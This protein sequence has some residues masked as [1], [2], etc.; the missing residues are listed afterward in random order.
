MSIK[1]SF[2][3]ASLLFLLAASTAWCQAPTV[4]APQPTTGTV[5]MPADTVLAPGPQA[6]APPAATN[7]PMDNA[8]AGVDPVTGKPLP[9]QNSWI[10]Y[11]QPGCCGPVGGNGPIMMELFLRSGTVSP[12]GGTRMSSALGTGWEIW[13]GGRSLFFNTNRDKAFT[14][15]LGLMNTYNRGNGSVT[16]NLLGNPATISSLNRTVA[17]GGLGWECFCKPVNDCCNGWNWRFGFDGGGGWGTANLGMNDD[18]FLSGFAR[19]NDHPGMLY[20]AL[21]FDIEKSWGCCTW[22]IGARIEDDF[23]WMQVLGGGSNMNSI[24]ALMNVNVR[25]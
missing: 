9:V 12:V 14:V 4:P 24:N 1:A 11:P 25:F 19:I 8:P 15:E 18:A 16:W 6:G 2:L 5:Y 13:G 21:H 3:S 17:I 7:M 10:A 23:T 22:D 20:G